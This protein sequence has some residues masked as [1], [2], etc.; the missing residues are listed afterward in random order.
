M[1]ANTLLQW[2]DLGMAGALGLAAVGSGLGAGIAGM[3][4][5]GAWKKCLMQGKPAPFILLVFVGAPLTQTI[6][7]MIVMNSMAGLAVK[8]QFLWGIGAFCGADN[9]GDRG[10]DFLGITSQGFIQSSAAQSIQVLKCNQG[11]RINPIT[12]VQPC[13][14]TERLLSRRDSLVLRPGI[15]AWWDTDESQFACRGDA[16]GLPV[17]ATVGEAGDLRRHLR[18]EVTPKQRIKARDVGTRINRR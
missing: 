5:C 12:K 11:L 2:R 3:A 10:P 6:Y 16:I 9:P 14:I 7:G 13:K 18:D 8:G 1:D 4:A 17:M 15:N